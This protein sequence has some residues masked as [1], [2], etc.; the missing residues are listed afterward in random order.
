MGNDLF[1]CSGMEEEREPLIQ[2]EKWGEPPLAVPRGWGQGGAGCQCCAGQK[3]ELARAVLPIPCSS[4]GWPAVPTHLAGLGLP[5]A[6][7][8][9]H[10]QAG[11][12]GEDRSEWLCPLHGGLHP[13]R[14]RASS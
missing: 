2:E 8:Y 4:E 1:G 7:E 12:E 14:P 5:P 10:G 3:Q 11:Q 9:G 13:L 6:L